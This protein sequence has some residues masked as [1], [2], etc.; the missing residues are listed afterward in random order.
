LI[1]VDL[2][3]S[4]LLEEIGSSTF[5]DCTALKIIHLPPNLKRIN[6]QA[7]RNCQSLVSIVI[8]TL[9]EHIGHQT[10]WTCCGLTKVTFQSTRHLR[11]LLNGSLFS[12]EQF[13]GCTALHTLELQGRTIPRKL[14]PL[15]LEQFLQKD[16]G[17]LARTDFGNDKQRITIAWNYV[18][19]N[20]ANFYLLDE[21]KPAYGRKRDTPGNG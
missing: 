6:V 16:N 4:V 13:L 12:G 20:I 8:P 2:S 11:T 19:A 1:V 5:S 17:I 7:F 14:W 10:F 18:R 9:V 3:N 21:T 15:L